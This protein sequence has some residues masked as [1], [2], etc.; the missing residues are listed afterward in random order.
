MTSTPQMIIEICPHEPRASMCLTDGGE[1]R[2][3]DLEGDLQDCIGSGD[4]QPACEYVLDQIGVDFRI[5]ARNGGGVYENRP[6]TPE[7]LQVTCE[8]IYF[9]SSSDFSDEYLA[10]TY[11][12]WEAA[13][14]LEMYL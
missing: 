12:V 13:S 14:E 1:V 2:G 7:E 11:L 3:S 9:E 5:V 6:A 8:N 10:Q 4:C